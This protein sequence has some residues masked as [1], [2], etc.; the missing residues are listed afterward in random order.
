[1]LCDDIS[2]KAQLL[3]IDTMLVAVWLWCIPPRFANISNF[4]R[5]PTQKCDLQAIAPLLAAEGVE[6]ATPLIWLYRSKH[7]HKCALEHLV[8]VS[9]F[10]NVF[11]AWDHLQSL[12]WRARYLQSLWWSRKSREIDL[13]IN[14][15]IRMFPVAPALGLA[16]L[17]GTKIITHDDD[18]DNDRTWQGSG[19]T[20]NVARLNDSFACIGNLELSPRP[21]W[22]NHR[23][24]SCLWDPLSA[25]NF[26]F[27]ATAKDSVAC[28]SVPLENGATV[29]FA[30]LEYTI[31]TAGGTCDMHNKYLHLLLG[32]LEKAS[33]INL[34]GAYQARLCHFL[35][36]STKYDAAAS[37]PLLPAG[38][39]HER[40]I[41][42]SRIS[43]HPAVLNIY[44]TKL[45]DDHLAETY[46]SI[47]WKMSTAGYHQDSTNG[48]NQERTKFV[49][50]PTT[51]HLNYLG[52]YITLARCYATR[53][54]ISYVKYGRSTL[55]EMLDLICRHT[56]KIDLAKVLSLFPNDVA[57]PLCM[58][59]LKVY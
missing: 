35:R 23:L 18:D 4:L 40:G 10:A 51:V 11:D 24:S 58:E 9:C 48:D 39:L 46:C 33:D 31:Y 3:L 12:R 55:A 57:L 26:F 16:V 36:I 14:H 32:G 13:A 50:C 19:N 59:F 27:C 17:T 49:A 22:A 54:K 15:V 47:T 21:T 20:E 2:L 6:H 1:M 52:I 34:I 43:D 30:Y 41:V 45:R 28:L 38:Y 8:K 5:N 29:A 7:A 53:S 25:L 44:S 56:K 42:L 37:F